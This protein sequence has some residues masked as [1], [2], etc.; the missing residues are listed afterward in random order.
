MI[1]LRINSILMCWKIFFSNSTLKNV[2][3][4]KYPVITDLTSKDAINGVSTKR[5]CGT[6]PQ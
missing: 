1:F 4:L 3:H 6:S 5:D 2:I